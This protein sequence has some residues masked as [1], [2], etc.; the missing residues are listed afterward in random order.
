MSP[1][2]LGFFHGFEK[3]AAGM[4]D[5]PQDPLGRRHHSVSKP[6]P[7]PKPP[8]VADPYGGVARSIRRS[9]KNKP[10]PPRYGK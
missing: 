5:M 9:F 2:Y 4:M 6:P 10:K 1:F 3:I 8:V 7:K